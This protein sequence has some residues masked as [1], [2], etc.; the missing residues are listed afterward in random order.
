MASKQDLRV[1]KTKR[2]IRQAFE[3]LLKTHPL[4]KITVTELAKEAEINKATFYLHYKDIY[5]LYSQSLSDHMET[6]AGRIDF[7]DLFFTDTEAFVSELI[8]LSDNRP[9]FEND[10]Y[11]TQENIQY[12]QMAMQIF[13]GKIADK[14]LAAGFIPATDE[15][16]M[17]LIF[18][19]SGLGTLFRT[20]PDAEHRRTAA[21]IFLKASGS[22]F[23]EV[24]KSVESE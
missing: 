12:N 18:L 17:K 4:S 16:R 19:F 13:C 22:L 24:Q 1:I 21:D 11:M 2:A 10:P 20:L 23:K 7:I 6:L 8:D 3:N 5:D 14:A 9:F 15:N